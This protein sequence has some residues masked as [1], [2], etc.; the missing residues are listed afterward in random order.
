ML[1]ENQKIIV[2][3][4]QMNNFGNAVCHIDG[5]VVFVNGAVIG[6]TVEAEI[7]RVKSNYAIASA[8]KI[9]I[10]SSHR[11]PV[12][13]DAF[14]SC[15]GCSF[16]TVHLDTENMVKE[17]YVIG[18]LK[19]FGIDADVSPIECPSDLP[20]RNKVV[21]FYDS[22]SDS[23]G[24]MEHATN[25]VVKHVRCP[26]N[27]STMDDIVAFTLENIEKTY[28]RALYIRKN[29]HTP[30]KYMVCPIFKKPTDIK[31][32]ARRLRARFDCVTSIKS[33]LVAGKDFVLNACEIKH[34]LGSEYLEDEL[35][36]IKVEI[37][38]KSFYQ[39]NHKCATA[40][41][42]RAISLLDA[43]HD[44]T[45]ADLF[46]G[47]GTIG[48]IV[49]KRTGA[50]VYGVEIEPDAVSDAKRNAK[51]NGIENIEFFED[52]A[53]NFD[54]QVDAC[55]ID[56]PRKGCSDFM[57]ET[58]LRLAPKKIVYISCNP[59]T[60]CRDIKRLSKSY[61]ISSPVTPYN[62]FPRT[63]HVESLVCLTK[64]TN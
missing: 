38:A 56:P 32:Y 41:Y 48:L 19:K 11:I 1:K 55:I 60:M 36:S 18:M 64:Q 53:G 8:T 17:Q 7:Q 15:G 28:L 62:M 22:K 54:K 21:L 30:S 63:S 14:G 40:L 49:A 16:G 50:K 47:T 59:D 52:D 57:I 37:S 44:S 5:F 35:C 51:R 25:R 33:G 34:A 4:E 45:V 12:E 20:Y 29:S 39:V 26:L 42:E 23:F 3:C 46:C 9:L 2:K 61:E 58:L 13:C 43:S 27:D 24:Y 6:D 10:P 31:H